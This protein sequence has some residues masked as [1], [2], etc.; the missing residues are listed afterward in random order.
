MSATRAL[1]QDPLAPRCEAAA[2]VLTLREEL[3]ALREELHALRNTL[4]SYNAGFPRDDDG[5]PDTLGHRR[6]HESLIRRNEERTAFLRKMT[7]ELTKWGLIGFAIWSLRELWI[8]FLK[9][10]K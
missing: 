6:Y 8:A 2:E 9:G 4:D 5:R 1:C 7:F 10:P 3:H